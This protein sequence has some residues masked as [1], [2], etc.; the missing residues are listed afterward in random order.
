MQI[1][2]TETPTGGPNRTRREEIVPLNT[3]PRKVEPEVYFDCSESEGWSWES[4]PS[5]NTWAI[6]EEAARQFIV[7][8]EALDSEAETEQADGS[9]D[10]GGVFFYPFSHVYLMLGDDPDDGDLNTANWDRKMTAFKRKYFKNGSPQGGT[11]I[12]PAVRAGDKHYLGEFRGEDPRARVR[13]RVAFSDGAMSDAEA[14]MTYLANAKA[15][16]E[17]YGRHDDGHGGVWDEVWA[18]CILGEEGGGGHAAYDQ[19]QEIAKNHP[20]VH[21][22]Y[23]ADVVNP[24]EIAEDMAVAVIPTQA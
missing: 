21:A 22:Y 17:G 14:F 15:T 2:R 4:D 7:P 6:Q 20:W 3:G 10:D 9:D 8:F 18:V 16:D 23:F 24:A 11:Q 1:T 5:K 13:A 12:M 19:Y